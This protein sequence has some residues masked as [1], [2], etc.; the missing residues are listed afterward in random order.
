MA[1]SAPSSSSAAAAAVASGLMFVA[2]KLPHGLIIEHPMN[3]NQTVTLN[4]VNRATIIGAPYGVTE[5]DESFWNDWAAVN[6]KFSAMQSGAIFA[7]SSREDLEALARE[8][9]KRLSGFE[10]TPQEAEGVKKAA[11]D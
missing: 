2:C 4:G 8:Y 11:Q 6:A 10:R 5:V 9:E 7:A 3:P 1:R